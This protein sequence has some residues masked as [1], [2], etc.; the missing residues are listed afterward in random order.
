MVQ[1]LNGLRHHAVIRSDHK[2][3]NVGNLRAAGTHS[4]KRL[5]TGGIDKGNRTVFTFDGS[6]YLIRTDVLGNAASFTLNDVGIPNSVQQSSFTMVN[7][8][9]HSHN[10]RT[11]FK[12]VIA[13]R[14]CFG[15]KVDVKGFQELAFFV[16]RRH[17]LYDVPQLGTQ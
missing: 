14:L 4:G 6:V 8:T 9:H 7:V 12:N 10:R 5:V 2:N 3:G 15:F 13:F 16:L 11:H 1:R 17:D